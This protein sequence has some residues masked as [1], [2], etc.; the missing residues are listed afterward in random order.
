VCQSRTY[1]VKS[2]KKQAHGGA[3]TTNQPTNQPYRMARG[4]HEILDTVDHILHGCQTLS[5]QA[6]EIQQAADRY[7]VRFPITHKRYSKAPLS[8]SL[9][10]A[11]IEWRKI[12]PEL[13]TL[14]LL[15]YP[16]SVS[17]RRSFTPWRMKKEQWME[18]LLKESMRPMIE[19]LERRRISDQQLERR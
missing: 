7:T 8:Q 19:L 11:P 1:T 2:E 9:P 10:R 12:I 3:T 14:L 16:P 13:R 17:D 4:R 5:P 6:R 15:G 18:G